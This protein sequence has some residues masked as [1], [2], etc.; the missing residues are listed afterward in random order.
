MVGPR[1]ADVITLPKHARDTIAVVARDAAMT[2]EDRPFPGGVK[3]RMA[4]AL[5][6]RKLKADGMPVELSD[7]FAAFIDP[8]D[9]DDGDEG[10]TEGEALVVDGVAT[11]AGAGV[12]VIADAIE[13]ASGC[14]C[15]RQILALVRSLLSVGIEVAAREIKN[16]G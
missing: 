8:G 14:T 6:M 3:F 12:G 13:D 11:A 7:T 9:V 16:A 1:G 5:G 15:N 10:L 2:V 4:V